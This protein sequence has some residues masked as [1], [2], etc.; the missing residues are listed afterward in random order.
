MLVVVS[1]VVMKGCPLAH[2]QS[3]SH[4]EV[5]ELVLTELPIANVRLENLVFQVDLVMTHD[6]ELRA[7]LKT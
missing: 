2:L 4:R 6:T 1:E 5:V 7:Q 3:R